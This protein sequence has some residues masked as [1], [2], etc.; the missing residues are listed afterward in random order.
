MSKYLLRPEFLLYVSIV[1]LFVAPF[2][3]RFFTQG[4]LDSDVLQY[5]FHV[6][7]NKILL[8]ALFLFVILFIRFFFLWL[9]AGFKGT[10]PSVI[11]S[12]QNRLRLQSSFFQFLKDILQVGLPFIILFYALAFALGQLN[13][14]NSTR[15]QDELLLAWDVLIT[16]TFLPLSLTSFTY[17]VWFVRVVEISFNYLLVVFALLG[18]YLFQAKQ[19]LFREA[20]GV[21]AIALLFMFAGWILFPVMSPHDRFIDNV[22]N[23]SKQLFCLKQIP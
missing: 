20:V 12:S 19:K 8:G 4:E 5:Y 21:Y 17:P 11:F 16:G 18:A 22:Y 1:V 7:G 14:F 15:L 3:L 9:I 23:L 13:L 10:N 2:I 6:T